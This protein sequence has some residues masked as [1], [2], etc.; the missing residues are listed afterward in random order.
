MDLVAETS[1]G[2]GP[3]G[4][5]GPLN[6]PEPHTCSG[7]LGGQDFLDVTSPRQMHGKRN[8]ATTVAIRLLKSEHVRAVCSSVVGLCH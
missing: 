7:G 5:L 1:L 6:P 2:L 3:V 4:P 8:Y